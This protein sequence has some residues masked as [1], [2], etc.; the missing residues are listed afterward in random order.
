M[1]ATASDEL[2]KA[3]K[4]LLKHAKDVRMPYNKNLDAWGASV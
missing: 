3:C 4:Q 1:E 2:M